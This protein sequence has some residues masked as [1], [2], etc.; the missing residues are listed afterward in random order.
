MPAMMPLAGCLFISAGPVDLAGKIE[1]LHL[2]HLQAPV[3]LGGVHAVY[4]MA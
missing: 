2:L 4:S 1:A 3:E